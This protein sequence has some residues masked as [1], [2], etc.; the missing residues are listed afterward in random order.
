MLAALR[1]HIQRNKVGLLIV[2]YLQLMQGIGR[3]ENRTQEVSELSR[4]LKLTAREFQIPVVMLSQLN[5]SCASEN[6]APALHDLRESGSIEHDSDNVIFVHDGRMRKNE[7]GALVWQPPHERAGD[8]KESVFILAKQRN[9]TSNKTLK[10]L[11]SEKQ[12]AFHEE[13]PEAQ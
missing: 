4:G 10:M 6:R 1:R 11:F 12:T 3:K 7:K 9:G 5:R 2:D 13:A 8:L